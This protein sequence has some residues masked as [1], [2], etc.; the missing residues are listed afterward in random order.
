MKKKDKGISELLEMLKTHPEL[1]SALVLDP[2]RVK[3][4][5]RSKAARRLVG[6]VNTTDFLAKVAESGGGGPIALCMYE[7]AR[8]CGAFTLACGDT[9]TLLPPQKRRAKPA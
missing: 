1:I 7:T 6:G 2:T 4:L 8:L 3:R 9:E 5:L